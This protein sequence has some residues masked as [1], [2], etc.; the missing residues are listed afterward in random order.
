MTL[1]SHANLDVN[2]FRASH[3]RVSRGGILARS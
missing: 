2:G 1:A 3:A